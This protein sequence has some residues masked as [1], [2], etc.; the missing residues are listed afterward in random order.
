MRFLKG[1]TVAR[2]ANIYGVPKGVIYNLVDGITNTLLIDAKEK[3][4]RNVGFRAEALSRGNDGIHALVKF[5]PYHYEFRWSIRDVKSHVQLKLATHSPPS[6]FRTLTNDWGDM[7]EITD[8]QW[9]AVTEFCA[10]YLAGKN[11]SEPVGR[12]VRRGKP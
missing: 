8:V 2:E 5:W 7:E 1:R 10:G 11:D 4:G 9:T 12:K 6:L 3:R